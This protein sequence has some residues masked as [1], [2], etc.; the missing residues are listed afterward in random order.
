[1]IQTGGLTVVG[2]TALEADVFDSQESSIEAE[3]QRWRAVASSAITSGA[4]AGVGDVRGAWAKSEVTTGARGASHGARVGFAGEFDRPQPDIRRVVLNTGLL[5]ALRRLVPGLG[6][7]AGRRPG[8]TSSGAWLLGLS[9]VEGHRL[10]LQGWIR[11]RTRTEVGGSTISAGFAC[12]NGAALVSAAALSAPPRRPDRR[13]QLRRLSAAV[14]DPIEGSRAPAPNSARGP[15]A[16]P[17][18]ACRGAGRQLSLL[19]HP[20]HPAADIRMSAA[21]AS[22]PGSTS[23]GTKEHAACVDGLAREQAEH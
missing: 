16:Q 4:E 12:V 7:P 20:A 11:A 15:A 19:E 10:L 23:P 9:K 6:M 21:H 3:L 18:C 8:A 2:G 13:L 22:G 1:M 14:G 5:R 17:T